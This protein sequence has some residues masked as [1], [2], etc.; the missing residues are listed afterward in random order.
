LSQVESNS[1]ETILIFANLVRLVKVGHVCMPLK[2]QM[3]GISKQ[4]INSDMKP[5]KEVKFAIVTSSKQ[6]G[7]FDLVISTGLIP[8]Q[9]QYT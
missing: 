1:A 8:P 9:I 2:I 6:W 5:E 4:L 3:A 7:L